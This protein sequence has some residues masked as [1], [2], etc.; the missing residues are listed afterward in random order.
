MK[1]LVPDMSCKHCVMKIEKQLMMDGLKAKVE[2]ESKSVSFS[3]DSDLDK[4]SESI[5]KAGY[6][7]EV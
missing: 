5:K 1:V 6:T 3:K 4:V 7:P 2:L